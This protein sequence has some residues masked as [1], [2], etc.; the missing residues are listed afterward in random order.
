MKLITYLAAGSMVVMSVA[1]VQAS[2][3]KG[4]KPPKGDKSHHNTTVNGGPTT[5]TNQQGQLQGQI[6]G[7]KQGQAQD[8]Q[9]SLRNTSTNK[10]GQAQSVNNGQTVAPAQKTS[11]NIEGD[12]F[13][14]QA[15]PAFAAALTAAPETCMGSTSVGASSP[16]GGVSFG[17]T[18]KSGDCELRMFARALASLGQSQAALILLAHGN[19]GVARALRAAGIQI[20]GAESSVKADAVVTNRGEVTQPQSN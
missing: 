19:E 11:V 2:D 16:F 9:Q 8:Q 3:D 14:R 13:P 10:N 7:Q 15:P 17:T 1:G 12:E 18:W 6:Q 4:D 20:P 5:N